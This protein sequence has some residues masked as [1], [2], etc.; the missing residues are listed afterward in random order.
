MSGG[1]SA[2]TWQVEIQLGEQDGRTRAVARLRTHD[3]TALVG[4]G[5]ARL[6]AT[7]RD[8]PE[9]GAELAAA[10]ALHDLADRLL[11]AA[12]GDI[13]DATHED[14]ELRDVR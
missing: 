9:I 6:N 14:V 4:T 1:T 5:L 7:D 2:S 10:R 8:V 3:R 13:A 11:G 12:V